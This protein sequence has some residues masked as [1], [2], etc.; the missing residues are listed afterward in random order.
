MRNETLAE[1]RTIEADFS[2]VGVLYLKDVEFARKNDYPLHLQ[3]L[4]PDK[5]GAGGLGAPLRTERYPLVAFVQGAGWRKQDTHASL[6]ALCSLVKRGYVVA[7]IEH[8]PT[9]IACFPAQVEDTQA[10]V[11]FLLEH[12]DAYRIDGK[13]LFL[14]GDSSGGHTVLMAG[15]QAE[16]APRINGII[17]FYGPT[18]LLMMSAASTPAADHDAPES[19]EGLL[20]GGKRVSENPELARQASPLHVLG[21]ETPVPPVLVMHGSQD[22]VVDFRQSVVLVEKLKA[23]GKEVSFYCVEGGDHG[24]SPFWSW[25]VLEVVADFMQQHLT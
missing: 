14:W 10:A 2:N 22:S 5:P 16:W 11:R 1:M 15:M 3:I 24:G 25:A 6:P 18:D 19:P 8:C 7:S 12:A 4:V 23:L 20:I 9:A 17:D 13:N 21:M